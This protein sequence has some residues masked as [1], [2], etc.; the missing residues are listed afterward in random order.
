MIGAHM[1]KNCT[2]CACKWL[3]LLLSRR[4]SVLMVCFRASCLSTRPAWA[5]E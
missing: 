1:S 3:L 4:S 5:Q 2:V